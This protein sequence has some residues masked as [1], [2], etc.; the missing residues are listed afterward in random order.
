[1][2]ILLKNLK[3]GLMKLRIENPEDLWYLS[4]IIEVGDVVEGQTLRKIKIGGGEERARATEKKRVFMSIKVEKVEFHDYSNQLRVLG[5][6]LEGPDDVPK[7]SYHSFGL[8]EQ[9]T[10]A[11]IKEHWLNY[12][13]YKLEEAATI[14]LPEIMLCVLDREH[15]YFARLKRSNYDILSK[16][17]GAVER[18]VEKAEA[19]GNFYAEV[20]KQISDYDQRYKFDSIVIASPVFFKEDLMKQLNDDGLKKK[21]VLAT[22]SSVT[23]NAFREVLARQELKEVLRK[24]RISKEIFLVDSLLAEISKNGL[25]IYGLGQTKAAAEAGA[26][27]H[28][29]ITDSLIHTMKSQGRYREIDYIMRQAEQTKAAIGI[30]SADND[31]GKRLNGLGG[32][33]ALL[34]YRFTA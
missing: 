27:N 12:Q 16:H 1:M 13:L 2:K 25:A 6:I 29:L 33:A 31:A 30:I 34:R 22:C 32:I 23:E 9:T 28:L 15:A 19:R 17:E 7:G 20:I 5:T 10:V 21:I 3:K 24:D 8:E 4:S 18:K 26:I 11:I 14:K